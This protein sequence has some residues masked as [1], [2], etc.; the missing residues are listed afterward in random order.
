MNNLNWQEIKTTRMCPECGSTAHYIQVAKQGNFLI[1]DSER[2]VAIYGCRICFL[3]IPTECNQVYAAF[4]WDEQ[5]QKDRA[6][7]SIINRI[8]DYFARNEF[9]NDDTL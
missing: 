3:I 1:S 7:K 9:N 6:S 2:F 4:M 8:D 5:I